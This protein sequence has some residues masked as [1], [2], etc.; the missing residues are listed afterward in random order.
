MMILLPSFVN[1]ISYLVD[2]LERERGVVAWFAFTDQIF[3]QFICQKTI[4]VCVKAQI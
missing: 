4:L 3:G 2:L 1:T